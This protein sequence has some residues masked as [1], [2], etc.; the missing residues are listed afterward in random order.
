MV[1]RV[2]RMHH[3]TLITRF[4]KDIPKFE[5]YTMDMKPLIAKF[6]APGLKYKPFTTDISVIKL[7]ATSRETMLG[8]IGHQ[9]P[10]M[11]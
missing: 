5:V 8:V 9:N 3:L 10:P 1:L 4:S 7:L 11:V 6:D 2:K